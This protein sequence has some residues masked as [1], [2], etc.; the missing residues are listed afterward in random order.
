M[1]T[2]PSTNRAWRRVTSL[3]RPTSL[4]TAAN[5]HQILEHIEHN[6]D[7]LWKH[8]FIP[9]V[10]DDQS[11]CYLDVCMMICVWLVHCIDQM[12]T[13]DQWGNWLLRCV[14][15]YRKNSNIIRTIFTNNRGPIAGVRIIH[16]N[17]KN[18]FPKKTFTAHKYLYQAICTRLFSSS[19]HYITKLTCI[20]NL[21][22]FLHLGLPICYAGNAAG[23]ISSFTYTTQ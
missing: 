15:E 8:E 20:K 13:E 18:N 9:S 12:E 16:V 11:V 23:P 2:H 5:R 17:S 19:S 1:V 6:T 4:S 10:C 7:I 3:I 21:G 14:S 22:K